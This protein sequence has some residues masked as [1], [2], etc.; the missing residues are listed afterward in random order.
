MRFLAVCQLV[1]FWQLSELNTF[2]IKHIF[3]MPPGHPLVIIRLS[4]ITLVVAPSVRQV[5]IPA[6]F[7]C[8]NLI[9]Y[10]I[11]DVDMPQ[12]C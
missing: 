7:V 3:H 9:Y 6:R 12:K 1:V 8:L 2:F 5:S 10:L 11:T 4:I